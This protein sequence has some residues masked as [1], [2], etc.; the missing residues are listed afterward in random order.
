MLL[1]TV[2]LVKDESAAEANLMLAKIFFERGQTTQ[3]LETLYSLNENFQSYPY[4][5]GKSYITIGEIF[6]S[7]NDNFQAEATLL[8]IV[9]NTSIEEIKNEAQEL[10]N[11]INSNET[12]L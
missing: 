3:A 4:W 7:E 8:S 12:S 2:N 11:K 10:L 6:I 9:E 1:K 5:V